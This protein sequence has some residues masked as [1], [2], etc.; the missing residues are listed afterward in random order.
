MALKR[1]EYPAH[2]ETR[3]LALEQTWKVSSSIMLARKL[4]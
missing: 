4:V 2:C 3:E 1:F